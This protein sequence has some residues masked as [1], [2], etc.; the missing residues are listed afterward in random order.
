MLNA[1]IQPDNNSLDETER[2]IASGANLSPAQCLSIYQN[3]YITRLTKCL[4]E[5]FPALNTALGE[6]L[7]EQFAQLF[8]TEYPSNSYTLYDLGKRFALF[9]ETNRPDKEQTEKESWIDFMVELARYEQLHFSLFD[10]PGHEGKEWP[11]LNTPDE[12]L[13]LQP[14]LALAHY[15]Y[16]VGWYY[17]NCKQN[18]DCAFPAKEN[19]WIV[20]VRKDFY[21]TTYPLTQVHFEF[22][23]KLQETSSI[24]HALEHISQLTREPYSKVYDSWQSDVKTRWLKSGFFISK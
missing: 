19:S 17:H 9:L 2:L 1:L 10:A 16:P 20:L 11:A 13:V 12:K 7:F 23:K 4:A 18:S 15:Q 22:L 3:G 6:S 8:L 21:V 5:Q 24:S 14:C